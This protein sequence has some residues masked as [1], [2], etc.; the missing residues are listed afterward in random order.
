MI[1]N[2]TNEIWTKFSFFSPKIFCE[3][4]WYQRF[5]LIVCHARQR[6]WIIFTSNICFR[7]HIYKKKSKHMIKNH[8]D[9][10]NLN[11]VYSVT[12]QWFKKV[13]DLV[14]WE[15]KIISVLQFLILQWNYFFFKKKNIT[16]KRV[17]FC[18]INCMFCLTSVWTLLIQC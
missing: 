4:L 2:K 18:M 8:V 9:W 3:A 17:D 16:H 15:W 5:L 10:G 12:G 7:R 13:T 6:N 1:C 14:F 11:R